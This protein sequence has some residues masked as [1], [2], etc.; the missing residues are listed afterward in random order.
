[1]CGRFYVPVDDDASGFEAILEQVNR[2]FK[3]S[4]ALGEMKRGEIYPTE[5]VPVVT[6]QAPVLMKWGFSR[7]DGKGPII[8]AR[9]ETADEKPTFKK[10]YRSG[11][12]LI[13]A[14]HY[15]EWRK[16]GALKTKYAI[17][18]GAPIYMAGLY[19]NEPDAPLPLFV[20]LTRPAAP[21][22]SFIHD[23][24]PVLVPEHIRHKWLTEPVGSAELLAASEQ[25]L[26]Y[27][28][29]V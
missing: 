1:M 2:I 11:R 24:M 6:D 19:T 10:A 7:Y 16:D 3:G 17:G 21:G 8:N 14:G 28:E 5:I 18:T 27:K 9:L 13:P 4:P 29:A 15:F 22:I 25:N 26:V 20:I 23:R 12:C